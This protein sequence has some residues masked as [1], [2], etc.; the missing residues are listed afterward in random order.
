MELI[1]DGCAS[2]PFKTNIFVVSWLLIFEDGYCELSKF[3]SSPLKQ[4]IPS[5]TLEY[6]LLLP[7][8]YD[9]K[10]HK[11][12]KPLVDMLSAFPGFATNWDLEK[13]A[14]CMFVPAGA[15]ST[16]SAA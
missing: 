8:E 10:C 14:E 13:A 9:Q 11:I 4:A 7:A 6:F 5:L 3:D 2:V 16:H 15:N 12:N 1:S